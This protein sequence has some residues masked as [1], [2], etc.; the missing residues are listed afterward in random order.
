M[1]LINTVTGTL[2][3][4]EMGY[5]LCHTHIFI[6]IGCWFDK[7][8]YTMDDPVSASKV[9]IE[10][11]GIIRRNVLCNRDNLVLDDIDL[12]IKIGPTAEL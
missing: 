11:L 5:T 6:D 12:A 10:T 8:G 1:K 2:P 4:E 9:N 7:F 3:A